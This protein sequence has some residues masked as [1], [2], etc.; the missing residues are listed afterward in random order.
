MNAFQCRF[1]SLPNRKQRLGIVQ[2]QPL[3]AFFIR[4]F[5]FGKRLVLDPTA[6]FQVLLKQSA[7][8][9]GEIDAVFVGFLHTLSIAPRFVKCTIC[10]MPIVG[11]SRSSG[12][13]H[14]TAEAGGM[15]RLKTSIRKRLL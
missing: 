10:A 1:C 5:A 2:P 12:A 11:E 6:Q 9:F 4:A 13:F 8:P 14:P 7:L 15:K 3:A